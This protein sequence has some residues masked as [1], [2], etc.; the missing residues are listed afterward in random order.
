[1]NR[2][3]RNKLHLSKWTAVSPNNHE[4]HF[5][6]IKLIEDEEQPLK[7]VLEAIF[8]KRTQVCEWTALKDDSVWRQGWR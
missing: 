7:V 6:V 2:V 4:K 3:Q 1:M 8:S 5:I